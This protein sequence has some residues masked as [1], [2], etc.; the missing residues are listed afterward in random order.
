MGETIDE[1][2]RNELATG[3][4]VQLAGGKSTLT[5]VAITDVLSVGE[6]RK[7]VRTLKRTRLVASRTRRRGLPRL[8]LTPATT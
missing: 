7:A 4:T 2:T 3:A 5:D 6:L 1:L 8:D